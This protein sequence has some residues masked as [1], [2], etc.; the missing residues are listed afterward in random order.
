MHLHTTEVGH[1]YDDIYCALRAWLWDL[2]HHYLI[3]V[4]TSLKVPIS[5]NQ[6][7]C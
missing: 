3:G 7:L 6:P 1:V 4:G 2:S 5:K